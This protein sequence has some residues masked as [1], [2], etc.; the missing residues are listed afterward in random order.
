MEKVTIGIPTYNSE[1]YIKDCLR[2]ILS[3]TY[4]NLEIIV[5]DNGST[6]NT[7][8]I[9]FSFA[10]SRIRFHKNPENIYCYG[11]YNV[12]LHLAETELVAIYHSD[13]VYQPTIV[14]RQVEFLKKHPD[15]M[16]VFT[17][18]NII[19]AKGEIIGEWKIPEHLENTEIF[20]FYAAYN[21]FLKYGDFFICPSGMFVKKVFSEIGLFKEE[22]FF[23][24]TDDAYWLE[25][26]KKYEMKRE[27]Q[28]TANDLEMWL[29]ILQKFSVGILRKKLINYRVHPAQGTFSH[30]STSS[31]NYFIVM[32]YYEKYAREKNFLSLRYCKHYRAKKIRWKFAKGRD[33]LLCGDFKIAKEKFIRF[34]KKFYLICPVLT[35]KDIARFLFALAFVFLPVQSWYF[36]KK[37]AFYYMAYK[38]RKEQKR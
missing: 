37:I 7:E 6:D 10:D 8:K 12:I 1:K 38:T 11:S 21:N 9:V 33:A 4:A 13:D 27:M 2:S 18:A 24:I 20:D 29:R 36:F 35:F 34:I 22:D 31:E 15:V 19:N 16:A 3:Q 17:E 28:F 30:Y 23:Q 25:L 5:V 26:L 32:D 14:E